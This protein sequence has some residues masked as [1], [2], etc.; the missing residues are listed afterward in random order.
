MKTDSLFDKVGGALLKKKAADATEKIFKGLDSY[1]QLIVAICNTPRTDSHIKQMIRS[2]NTANKTVPVDNMIQKL[3]RAGILDHAYTKYVVNPQYR[4]FLTVMPMTASRTAE[5]PSFDTIMEELYEGPDQQ[6]EDLMKLPEEAISI[7][8]RAIEDGWDAPQIISVLSL[9][10]SVQELGVSTEDVAEIVEEY[11]GSNIASKSAL[12][13]TVTI[14]KS[15]DGA[16][17][18][19]ESEESFDGGALGELLETLEDEDITEEEGD[20]DE[21]VDEDGLEKESTDIGLGVGMTDRTER[22]EERESLIGSK[23]TFKIKSSEKK[24]LKSAKQAGSKDN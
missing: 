8:D 3:T 22:E 2:R 17:G 1:E 16:A 12:K 10:D 20:E 18:E 13:V 5:E 11:A 9:L 19:G 21:L 14:S 24:N 4:Q 23:K 6:P 15:E 7:L